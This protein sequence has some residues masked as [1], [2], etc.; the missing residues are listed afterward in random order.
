M[1]CEKCG[2]ENIDNARFCIKCGQPL[3][4]DKAETSQE[5]TSVSEE[6]P[7]NADKAVSSKGKPD[8]NRLTGKLK[9]VP[10]KVLFGVPAAIIA[11]AVILFISMQSAKTID[12]NKY[13]EI[14][15]T[16]YDGYGT[17]YV[18]IDWAAL[19]KDHG[20]DVSFSKASHGLLEIWMTPMEA[21]QDCVAVRLDKYDGLSNGDSVNYTWDISSDLQKY[22]ECSITYKDGEH[23]VS[24][25]EKLET[26]DAFAD[27]E[28]TFSG[29]SPMGEAKI[30]YNGS[31]FSAYDFSCDKTSELKNGDTIEVK[32]SGNDMGYYVGKF[33]KVPESAAKEYTVSGL[34]EYVTAFSDLTEDFMNNTKKEAEDSIYSYVAKSY[35]KESSMKNLEYA[36]YIFDHLKNENTRSSVFNHLYVIYRGDVSSSDNSFATTKVYYPVEFT[37]LVK[38]T[39]DEISFG[40]NEGIPGFS[41]LGS[42]WYTTSGYTNPLTCYTELVDGN[43]DEYAAEYGDG[44]EVFCEHEE[45]TKLEDISEEYKEQLRT[46]AKDRIESYMVNENKDT[47]NLDGL[48]LAGEYLLTAKS[49]GTDYEQNNKYFA[50]YSGT[51][52][53]PDGKFETQTIYFPV[54]YD[55]LVKLPNG[56]YMTSNTVGMLGGS[57]L[58]SNSFWYIS[59]GYLD[60]TQMY[61]D[62]VMA[63]R[64]SYTYEVSEGLKSFGE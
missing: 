63:N 57:Y 60:G 16:G 45:I 15:T 64:D 30:S 12:L 22:L 54:E 62:I 40:Q 33:G 21:L 20:N 31:D 61:S 23:T 36:G 59:K 42:F 27:V 3:S 39:G 19:E 51:I 6:A 47:M 34:Q 44:F 2:T 14:Q 26:F 10:K 58:S 29:I 13:L 28:V 37:N 35:S 25:L 52:S 4:P 48:T 17:A 49:Q 9:S 24:G 8:L 46:D 11:I 41:E 56:E 32:L 53:S 7:V 5:D 50:V 1:I 18:S 38:G 43:R 55:G